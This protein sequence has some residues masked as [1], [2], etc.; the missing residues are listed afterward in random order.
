MTFSIMAHP[1]R[2]KHAF[3]LSEALDSPVVFDTGAGLW[4]NAKKAWRQA[5]GDVHFVLQDDA[6]L[7]N[8]F[9]DKVQALTERY[10]NHAYCLYVGENLK[11][12]QGKYDL[13]VD[14]AE[15]GYVV[16]NRI[17]WGVALGL[18]TEHIKPFLEF[19]DRWSKHYDTKHCDTRLCRYIRSVGLKV[20]YPYPSLVDHRQ[21]PSLVG[22]SIGRKAYKF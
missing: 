6:I 22:D 17:H 2:M 3:K 16:H 8:G 18:P 7:C 5:E 9:T 15:R 14:Q 4:E 11:T 1:K 19:G 13:I 10:P 12:L 21:L 20:V